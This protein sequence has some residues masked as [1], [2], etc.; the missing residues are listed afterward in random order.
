VLLVEDDDDVRRTLRQILVAQGFV[1]QDVPDAEA[2]QRL[3][4]EQ[5]YELVVADVNLPGASG[6]ALLARIR[7]DRPAL[8][9]VLISGDDGPERRAAAQHLGAGF[10]AKPFS[11]RELLGA[12]LD[13]LGR[14]EPKSPS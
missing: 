2:A 14:S 11:I 10:L 1:C 4:D 9:V 6:L 5:R 8:P 12:I 13:A 7:V 3:L